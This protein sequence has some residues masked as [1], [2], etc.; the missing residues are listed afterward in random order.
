MQKKGKCKIPSLAKALN[1][2]QP[3]ATSSLNNL[4]KLGIINESTGNQR[5]RTFEYTRYIEILKE[6]T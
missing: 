6:G 3:T 5:D 1:I 2:S 4:I